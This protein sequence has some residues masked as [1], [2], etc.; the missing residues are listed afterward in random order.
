MLRRLDE[1]NNGM[2]DPDE[3]NGRAKFFLD[4]IAQS[5]GGLDF[6]R[7][8]SIE[9]LARTMERARDGR[10]SS[11]E[12]GS[13]G[14]GSPSGGAQVVDPLVPGFGVEESLPAPLQFGVRATDYASVK[15]TDEDRRQAEERIRRYDENR[16]GILDRD[17][18]SRGRWGDDPYT[19]DAN[20]DGKISQSELAVRYARRRMSESPTGGSSSDSQPSRSGPTGGSESSSGADPRMEMMMRFSFERYDVNKSGVFEKEEWAN[21]RT[22]PS[23]ADANRDGRITKE[24]FASWLQGRFGGSGGGGFA[25]GGDG[26]LGGGF[27]GPGGGEGGPGMFRGGGEGGPGFRGPGGDGER[28]GRR[29]GR[30]E[31]R[32]F[33]TARSSEDSGGSSTSSATSRGSS[34]EIKSYRALTALERLP[35]G[36]PGWWASCDVN[37]DGQIAMA[38]YSASWSSSVSEEF[39]QFD[40][41][42]DGFITAKEC[43]KAG[44][45]GV[46]RGTSS[47]SS[48]RSTAASSGRDSG[49]APGGG[50]AANSGT[51]AGS[52]AATTKVDSRIISYYEG[53]V[54]KYDK[55]SDGV[56]T[57]DEWS[58]MSKTPDKADTDGDGRITALELAVDS[59]K[60]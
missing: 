46:V 12:E 21:F 60:K 43:L 15:I 16:D 8:I 42:Q 41:N 32:N 5:V 7:P 11:E 51:G 50:S 27:R 23:A 53:L 24:E 18:I 57:Q 47:S 1:N 26:G 34:N 37:A 6:S 56:L 54:K 44:E 28:S 19:Y 35:K 29:E 3:A 58:S 31:G 36:L 39:R 4:R 59:T 13:S 10:S 45:D 22:D 20:R 9:R 48:S 40:L 2:I 30:E 25:G 17:E 38:E 52:G 33:F 55:N 14:G 49:S